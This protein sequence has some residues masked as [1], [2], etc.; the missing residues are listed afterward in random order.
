LDHHPLL[1]HP[2]LHFFASPIVITFA[3]TTF[4]IDASFLLILAFVIVA[5]DA[6]NL[7]PSQVFIILPTQLAFVYVFAHPSFSYVR[8][9]LYQLQQLDL[10]QRRLELR[11]RLVFA[12]LLLQLM[13]M[14]HHHL[15]LLP[16]LVLQLLLHRQRHL[17]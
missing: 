4:V 8:S 9:S 16:P 2:N 14:Q 6:L 11:L 17:P 5:S 15:L 12:F 7:I 1:L 13:P 10:V 3:F